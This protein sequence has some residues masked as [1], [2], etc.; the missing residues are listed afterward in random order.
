MMAS[1]LVS[2]VLTLAIELSVLWVVGLR[3]KQDFLVAVY[4]NML[5][6]PVVVF[7]ANLLFLFYPSHAWEAI[8]VLEVAAVLTEGFI[9]SRYLAF[10][11]VNPWA[12]SLVANVISFETGIVISYFQLIAS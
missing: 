4:A 2:L 3:A 12:L 8:A 10:H 6:N 1:L 7:L 11:N 5:T 9:F